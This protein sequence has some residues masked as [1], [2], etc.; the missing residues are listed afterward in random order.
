LRIRPHDDLAIED[1]T[2]S[3]AGDA[4]IIFFARGV[5]SDV[6]ETRVGIEVLVAHRRE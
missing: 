3:P 2:T 4:A 6:I 5:G 1:T